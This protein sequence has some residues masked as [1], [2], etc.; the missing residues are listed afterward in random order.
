MLLTIYLDECSD[1]DSLIHFLI[2]AGHTVISPRA[3][4]TKGWEDSDHLA[5]A[6][7]HG[8]VLLTDNPRDFDELH[9][10]WQAQGRT[11]SGIFLVYSDNNVR[12]DM[13]YADIVRSIENLL[14]S[15]LPR[16]NEIYILN[17]W[18]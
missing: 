9:K 8:Y 3:A 6:A 1:H 15:G 17:Q 16:N 4:G 13:T 12:K 18:R 14:A 10:R 2:Q 11:H 7:V 5:Y